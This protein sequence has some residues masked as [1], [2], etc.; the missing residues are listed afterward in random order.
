MKIGY[1]HRDRV[2]EEYVPS[3]EQPAAPGA[4]K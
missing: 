3:W 2:G 4:P 1:D